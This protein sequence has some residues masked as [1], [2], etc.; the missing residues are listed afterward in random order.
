[1]RFWFHIATLLLLISSASAQVSSH[2]SSAFKEK[3]G[4][5]PAPKPQS[6][7]LKAY[8]PFD[9]AVARVNGAELTNRD[10]L[11]EMYLIFP[12][13]RTH[14]GFPKGMEADIRRGA[15]EMIVFEELVYQEAE[16]RKMQ[17]SD[18]LMKKTEKEF[19][20][21]FTSEGEF[22]LYVKLECQGSM[23]VLR[24]RF[25]RALL[26]DALLQKEVGGRSKVSKAEAKAYY[27]KNIKEF[28]HED[29]LHIQTISVIPPKNPGVSYEKE[30][31]KEAEEAHKKAKETKSFREFGLLAE[32]VSDDDWHVNMGNRKDV[33]A[34]A[35]P[36]PIVDAARKMK[37]GDVSELFQ[38]G[39]NFTFFRLVSFT[40]AHV[41]KFSEVEKKVRENLEK[42]RYDEER[43]AFN[44]RLRKRSKVEVL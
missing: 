34:A 17:V 13:A 2:K 43:S 5:M 15:L 8:M 9:A 6:T 3:H 12:Y 35:L 27:E 36:K 42:S 25:R 29:M 18:D 23:K 26:I 14:K 33:P 41:D 1:M 28:T 40:P 44:K 39:P 16:R 7:G 31:R 24:E 11:R 38:F 10:L 37:P 30:A 22:Q 4:A 19:R 32:Q 20:K 21:Q